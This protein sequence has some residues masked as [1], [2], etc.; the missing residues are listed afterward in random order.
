MINKMCLGASVYAVWKKRNDRSFSMIICAKEKIV[1]NIKRVVR[2]RGVM[3]TNIKL[4]NENARIA[5]NGASPNSFSNERS[6][7]PKVMR[8]GAGFYA[9]LCNVLQVTIRSTPNHNIPSF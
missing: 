9:N 4:T 7:H 8:N 2:D 1:Q 5:H 3:L 6:W